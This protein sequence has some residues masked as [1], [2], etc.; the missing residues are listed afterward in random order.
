MAQDARSVRHGTPGQ[1]T[2]L[3]GVHDARLALLARIALDLSCPGDC[4]SC[5][6]RRQLDRW[7]SRPGAPAQQYTVPSQPG[8]T[9]ESANGNSQHTSQ[10]PR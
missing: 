7:M 10:G 4:D 2:G 5:R 8:S 9:Q 3:A 1:V 6:V